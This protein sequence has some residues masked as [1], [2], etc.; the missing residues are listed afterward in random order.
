MFCAL[1]SGS[2]E[3]LEYPVASACGSKKMH[4]L[5]SFGLF[6]AIVNSRDGLTLGADNHGNRYGL[7]SPRFTRT[8]AHA[9]HDNTKEAWM[10]FCEQAAVEQDPERLLQLVKEINRMLDEKENRLQRQQNE[11][12]K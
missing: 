1:V 9:M 10:Y 3:L 2:P 5:S 6:R 12:S 4:Q 7:S 8:E 11:G